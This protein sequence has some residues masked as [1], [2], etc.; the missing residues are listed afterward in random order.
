MI[1]ARTLDSA[2]RKAYRDT[3][4]YS[5]D[6]M[7]LIALNEEDQIL[8]NYSVCFERNKLTIDEYQKN[9]IS[10]NIPVYRLG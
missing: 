9:P 8:G 10:C 3:L 1:Q 5:S 7:I 4:G 2:L 6:G